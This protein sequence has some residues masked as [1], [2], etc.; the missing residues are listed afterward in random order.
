[1]ETTGLDNVG[2]DDVVNQDGKLTLRIIIKSNGNQA[3]EKNMNCK[4]PT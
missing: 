4:Q 3:G 1:M 2:D